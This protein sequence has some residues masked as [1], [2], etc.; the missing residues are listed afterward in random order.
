MLT[1]QRRAP[2][3][4]GRERD[5]PR[6]VIADAHDATR[7][8]VRLALEEDGFVVCAEKATATDA[9][10]AALDDRPDVCLLDVHMPGDGIRAAERISSQLPGTHVVMLSE[11]DDDDELLPACPLLREDSPFAEVDLV[12]DLRDVIQR[13]L[14]K[15]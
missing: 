5:A 9:V 12:G 3:E 14:R 15:L 1:V 8:G 4:H 2:E 10:A 7:T 13:L 6:I 11:S